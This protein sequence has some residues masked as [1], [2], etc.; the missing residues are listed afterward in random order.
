M[1]DSRTMTTPKA[2]FSLGLR[3]SAGYRST[4][5]GSRTFLVKTQEILQNGA[6]Q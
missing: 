2:V 3:G 6:G 5:A 4:H 1:R